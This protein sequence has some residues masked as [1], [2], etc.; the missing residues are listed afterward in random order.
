M[1]D[2]DPSSPDDLWAISDCLDAIVANPAS[3]H[4]YSLSRL[5]DAAVDIRSEADY[6]EMTA[7]RDALRARK[8]AARHLGRLER[9]LDDHERVLVRILSAEATARAK[10]G[11]AA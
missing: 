2:L 10:P 7:A 3:V 1:T 4:G 6:I 11:T 8:T 5:R 9:K